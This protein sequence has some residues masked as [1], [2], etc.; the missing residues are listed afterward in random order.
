MAIGSYLAK[1]FPGSVTFVEDTYQI[2]NRPLWD[3]TIKKVAE[4]KKLKEIEQR[5]Q[6]QED[7][8]K[9]RRITPEDIN[10]RNQPHMDPA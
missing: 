4:L 8:Q 2:N 5:K 1:N 10:T 3:A 9:V 6:M 7:M